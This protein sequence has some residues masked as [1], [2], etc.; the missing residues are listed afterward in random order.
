MKPTQI[1]SAAI[2]KITAGHD[3][4]GKASTGS[5]KTLAFGIPILEAYLARQAALPSD[6]KEKEKE[7]EDKT[8]IALILAPTRELAHQLHA[9]L[10][11][12]ARFAPDCNIVALTGGISLLKQQRQLKQRGGADILIATPGRLW[13]IVSEGQGWVDKLRHI[14]FLVVDEADRLL[15]EG[16]FKEVEEVLDLLSRKD[17]EAEESESESESEASDEEVKRPKKPKKPKKQPK[18]KAEE[19]TRQTLVFSATFHQGLQ[20]KLSAKGKKA[21]RG[22]GGGDLM[23]EEESMKYLLKKLRFREEKPQFVDV[24]PAGQLAE[25]LREGI[26]E[27]GPMEKDLYL[28]YLLLRYPCRTLVFTNSISSVKRLAPFLSELRVPAHPLHSSMLQKARLRNLERF[29]S[30]AQSNAVL[31]ATDVAARGLDIANVSMVVHYHLPRSADMYVHRSGRT[32]RADARGISVLLC[33]PEEV[34]G[35]RRLVFKVH[36]SSSS[37]GNSQELRGFDV[38]RAL[39]ARIRRRVVLARRIAESSLEKSRAGAEDAWL[40]AAADDLGVDYD[41]DGFRELNAKGKGAARGQRKKR[42]AAGVDKGELAGWRAELNSLLEKRV[43]AGGFSERYLT[44]KAGAGA[45]GVNLAHAL[46]ERGDMHDH[47][48][49]VEKRNVIDEVAW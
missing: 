33:A 7:S 1:Q 39:V 30:P 31:V 37:T 48:L 28:Y 49:G 35:V 45:G 4:I 2:P 8:P 27:C 22:T 13:E 41:S 21:W 6:S 12:L 25:Q 43:N 11:A 14:K 26:I 15:Q 44:A 38:D 3:L 17:D 36:S 42:Q 23:D 46:L 40:R 18:A 16:H 34:Q 24:N 19:T 9:H 10:T 20:Q 32:A 5:G 29:A 47:I